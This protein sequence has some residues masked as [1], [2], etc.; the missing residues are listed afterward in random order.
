LVPMK[1]TDQAAQSVPNLT[2][3]VAGFNQATIKIRN[4]HPTVFVQIPRIV[5]IFVALS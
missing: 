3:C 2:S 4:E 1:D 5:L